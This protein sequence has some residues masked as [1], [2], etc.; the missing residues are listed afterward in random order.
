[1]SSTV[2]GCAS[3]VAWVDSRDARGRRWRRYSVL[4]VRGLGALRWFVW[5]RRKGEIG[6]DKIE[7]DGKRGSRIEK[8]KSET[9]GTRGGRWLWK[10]RE[11]AEVEF[12]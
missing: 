2:R 12:W 7:C 4:F 9:R 8:S 1:M 5:S 10:G 3:A 11:S 6:I